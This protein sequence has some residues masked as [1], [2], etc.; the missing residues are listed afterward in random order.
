M[1]SLAVAIAIITAN[2]PGEKHVAAAVLLTLMVGAIA[3][4]PYTAWSKRRG[5]H[6]RAVP[7]HA[8]Y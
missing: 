1:S 2:F 4:L 6:R 3:A 7:L 5:E 8:Q